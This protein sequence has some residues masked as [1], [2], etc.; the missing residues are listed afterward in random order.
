MG[1]KDKT[2]KDPKKNADDKKKSS[3]LTDS[4]PI[5]IT[6]TPSSESKP[7]QLSWSFAKGN[8]KENERTSSQ[9]AGA[10][11]GASE[12]DLKSSALKGSVADTVAKAPVAFGAHLSNLNEPKTDVLKADGVKA[13]EVQSKSSSTEAAS[14]KTTGEV[15]KPAE[16]RSSS[17]NQQGHSDSSRDDQS[18]PTGDTVKA[19]GAS[20]SAATETLAAVH[21]AAPSSNQIPVGATVQ[22]VVQNAYAA[23]QPAA[24]EKTAPV[25]STA[26][27]AEPPQTQTIRPQNIDLKI[28]GADNSQVDVR[29]SQ[30]AGDVQVTVRTPDGD[31]AQSLRQHLPELSDRLSQTG[32]SGDLWQ[33]QS[34]QAANTGGNDA[35]SR[36]SDDAQTQQQDSG[37][38]ANQS[39]QQQE[40][41]T[42]QQSAWLNELN[43]A[44]KGSN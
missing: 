37:S 4:S 14:T 38:N 39:R 17:G 5:P 40:H 16:S 24:A 6:V 20:A 1:A 30:R 9:S 7:F 15:A 19:A 21:A 42:Q 29:I 18:A 32:V 2:E 26:A 12:Q 33:P 27:V 13:N 23:P 31:L 3:L 44:E 28:A 43:Q 22:N 36:Y 8:M 10:A 11:D 41:E 25:T 35:D 34:A